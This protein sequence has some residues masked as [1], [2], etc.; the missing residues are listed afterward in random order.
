MARLLT[1]TIFNAVMFSLCLVPLASA[2][3]QGTFD[4][5]D[6]EFRDTEAQATDIA[7]DDGDGDG[8][9]DAGLRLGSFQVNSQIEAGISH[10]RTKSTERSNETTQT[11][12]A[13]SQIVS[14]WSR[15]ELRLETRL[16]AATTRGVRVQDWSVG[17][18]VNGRRDISSRLSANGELR[19]SHDVSEE[20]QDETN[21]GAT[22]GL[23]LAPGPLEMNLRGSVDIQRVGD[24]VSGSDNGNDFGDAE[25]ELRLAYNR[26]AILAPFVQTKLT[27]R[28]TGSIDGFDGDAV[29]WELRTGLQIDRGEK[30]T[31][32]VSLGIGHIKTKDS[33]RDD[34]TSLLW[35]SSLTWSPVR[36][37]TV[38]L[39]AE[40]G[41]AF[42]ETTDLTAG[43]MASGTRNTNVELRAERSFNFR[44]DGFA[45][46]NYNYSSYG[47]I[48]RSDE[49]MLFS[50]GLTYALT[51]DS[52]LFASF[53]HERS[54]S[55]GDDQAEA[56]EINNGLAVRLQIRH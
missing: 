10:Q 11:F 12:S 32:E 42:S 43:T 40:G 26:G 28:N 14:Q 51:P 45:S 24:P 29:R 27:N 23:R 54:Q 38:T 39:A 49:T 52:S 6:L 5:E 19:L 9:G 48:D 18:V 7:E 53:T 35:A 33:R 1:R 4:S 41:L 13:E 56:D 17:L 37:T 31:G 21:Y 20:D 44:L 25:A 30:L 34:L 47:D 22:I 50:T 2:Q 36:L 15:H 46:A 55:S 3:E 16:D 8:D